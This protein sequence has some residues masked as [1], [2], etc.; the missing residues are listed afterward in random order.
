MHLCDKL[1][2]LF[3]P[4]DPVQ[5]FLG[6]STNFQFSRK[7]NEAKENFKLIINPFN[8]RSQQSTFPNLAWNS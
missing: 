2:A 4:W 3:N 7:E 8:P 1:F 6:R 5:R